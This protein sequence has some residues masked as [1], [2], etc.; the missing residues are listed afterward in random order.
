M[1]RALLLFGLLPA[2]ALAAPRPEAAAYLEEMEKRG[3]ADKGL[4]TPDRLAREV[5][6]A[7]QE[8]VT[9]EPAVAAAK[10]YAIVEGPR[11]Q[12]LAE[13]EDFQDAEYRLGLALHRGGSSTSARRYF[14]RSLARGPKA[15]LFY[16]ALRAYAD[17]CLEAH[18][19][20][21]CTA[22]L[23]GLGLDAT[24][25]RE[26]PGMFDEIAY[27]RGR[28]GFERGDFAEAEDALKRVGPKSRFFSSAL[29]LRGVMRVK[30]R[31]FTG[32]KDAFC[33]IADVKEGDALRFFI[34]GR[35]YALK[36]LARLGLARIA[37]EEG[38]YDDAF[39]HYFLIPQDSN[40]LAE[41]LFESAWSSLERKDYALGV[42]LTDE[43]LRLYPRSPKAAEARLLQATFKV[44]TCQFAAAETGFS[45]FISGHEPLIAALDRALADP[46]A[47]DALGLRLLKRS[48]DG[49]A[50]T[51]PEG[52]IVELLEVDQ[53]FFR[54]QAIARGL[55]KEALDAGHVERGWNALIA[56][57]SGAK[58]QPVEAG[59]DAAALRERLR[60]L[61]RE[62]ERARARLRE[63]KAHDPA[64]A[65]A[66][67]QALDALEAR[68]H[69][70]AQSLERILDVQEL[71]EGHAPGAA[72]L[73]P[74]IR[75][76]AARASA[77]KARA[78]ALAAKLDRA[79]GELVRQ[80]VV[81][82]R[83]Q[84]EDG[85]RR[86]RLG[87]IDAVVGQKRKLERQIENLAAGRFPPEMFG[88]LHIE[89]LI[90][91]DE[92]YWPPEEEIWLDEY[93]R[94]Q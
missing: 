88:K 60:E 47:L 36:D 24:A 44:K 61:G 15:P 77:L 11:F 23:D 6:A 59:L 39:Y 69:D 29:Y 4:G 90:G 91:D 76:D 21:A 12:D 52:K 67:K 73:L 63:R 68:R 40:R 51:D 89:G 27:L 94:Y 64:Q 32:A 71:D 16:A 37:H 38:R 78:A 53:R 9:G 75:A 8:L 85:L 22:E 87:K 92:E 49:P 17:V 74:M 41:A 18:T 10:L 28:A 1:S 65:A 66:L 48:T 79:A 20:A 42:Q 50:P 14:A 86:A 26:H 7:D 45:S 55:R 25:L 93:E 34:D 70:L 72:G 57:V 46:A 81:D 3:L 43:F 30:R 84:L 31:D 56:R 80:A 35:Y 5:R 13:T 83:A 54:V 62:V 2:A 19:L 58:V 82:L 33:E